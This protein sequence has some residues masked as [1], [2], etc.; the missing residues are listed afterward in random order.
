[1]WLH[2]LLTITTSLCLEPTPGN[3][4]KLLNQSQLKENHPIQ[5]SQNILDIAWTGN[6]DQGNSTETP[7]IPTHMD[8]TAGP[9]KLLCS[10]YWYFRCYHLYTVFDFSDIRMFWLLL[11]FSCFGL[12]PFKIIQRRPYEQA[13]SDHRQLGDLWVLTVL[14][15]QVG[16]SSPPSNTNGNFK[17]IR[18]QVLQSRQEWGS[19]D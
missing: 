1:M 12:V 15:T 17:F 3:H 11:F 19:L 13:C 4:R 14:T 18:I 7:L 10:D 8:L 5:T 16:V 6:N 9:S 2:Q